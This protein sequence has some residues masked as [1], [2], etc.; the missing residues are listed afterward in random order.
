MENR[1]VIDCQRLWVELGVTSMDSMKEFEGDGAV[2]Y[3][4]CGGGYMN[5]C[6]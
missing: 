6:D 1:S 5:L 4:D 2:L 3:P